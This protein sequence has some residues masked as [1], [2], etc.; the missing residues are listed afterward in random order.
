MKISNLQKLYIFSFI[1]LAGNGI[2]GFAV[3]KSNQKL[4][5]SEQ[6]VQH[7]E[8]IISQSGKILSLGVDIETS[9][10]VLLLL[11]TSYFSNP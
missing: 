9:S 10:R 4:R 5:E 8:Q 7:T 2:I 11:T 3:Y 1:I 6:K